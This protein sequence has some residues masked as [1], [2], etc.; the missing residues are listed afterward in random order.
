MSQPPYAKIL[1]AVNAGAPASGGITVPSAATIAL[2]GENTSFWGS[3][4]W[5]I[6]DFPPGFVAPAG[7]STSSS[8]VIFYTG[9]TPPSFTLAAAATGWGKY[10]LR[11]T[12]NQGVKNNVLDKTMVDEASALSMLSPNGQ[13]GLGF[14]ETT[15]FG[16]ARAQAAAEL[17]A[18]LRAIEPLLV[19]GITTPWHTTPRTTK[20]A[21]Y[22]IVATDYLVILRTNTFTTT[23]PASPVDGETYEVKNRAPTANALAG[24]GHNIDG[25]A[26]FSIPPGS[27]VKVSYDNSLPEWVILG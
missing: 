19:G 13:H 8:G 10:M 1:V 20:T 27:S 3:Q 17:S 18:T 14:N 21:N 12:V 9:V 2:T 23:L 25:A 11:L 26:S 22:T 24:N 15:Q 7:W 16:G 6:Y 5:E 4:L